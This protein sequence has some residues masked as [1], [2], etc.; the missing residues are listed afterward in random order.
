MSINRFAFFHPQAGTIYRIS[1]WDL[2]FMTRSDIL[3]VDCNY[4]NINIIIEAGGNMK[5]QTEKGF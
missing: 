1:S 2:N 4:K 5:W 3:D